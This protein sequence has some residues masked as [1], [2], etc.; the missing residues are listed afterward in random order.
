MLA[1]P[2]GISVVACVVIVI[3]IAAIIVLY[4]KLQKKGASDAVK[5]ST[6]GESNLSKIQTKKLTVH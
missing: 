3:L 2:I 4:R 6:E 5:I 1:L